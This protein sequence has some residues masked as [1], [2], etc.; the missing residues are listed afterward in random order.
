MKSRSYTL[1]DVPDPR[2]IEAKFV[3]N[4][5]V[6]DERTNDSGDARIRNQTLLITGGALQ[7]TVPRYIEINFD[8]VNFDAANFKDQKNQQNIDEKTIEFADSEETITNVGF[9]AIGETDS[10]AITR[11][12]EK[13]SSLSKVQGIGFNDSDQSKKLAYLMGVSQDDVQSIISP[14]ND[15]AKLMVNSNVAAKPESVFQMAAE[16]K[17]QSQINKRLYGLAVKGADD[18]SSLSRI[19]AIEMADGISSTF[20]SEASKHGLLD[21]DKEPTIHPIEFPTNTDE[22]KK[23]LGA[24][25]LGYVVTRY[26]HHPDGS[27]SDPK[28]FVLAGQHNTNLLDGEILYGESYTYEVRSVIRVDAIIDAELPGSSS[29]KKNWRVA[30]MVISKPSPSANVVSTEFQ[31][32]NEPDGVFYNF[33]YEAFGGLMLRWQVPS[34][35]SRDTKYFQ[36]FRRKTIF[37]PFTCIAMLDFDDS[38]IRTILPEQVR[39]E[40]VFSFP[41]ATTFYEDKAFKRDDKYI[42]AVAAIDA[43]GFSSGYSAQ[44]EVSFDKIRNTLVLK[45]ISRGGAPKQYPNFYVD[46]KLDDNFSVDS[47]T[48]D[49]IFDSG[50]KKM[51]VYFTP[52]ARTMSTADGNQENTFYTDNHA[53]AYSIQFINLDQQKSD[54]ALLTISDLRKLA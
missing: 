5:F 21:T 10:T 51:T 23:I 22:P 47:F 49:A 18:V 50:H 13:L 3:Y 28:N 38:D 25:C 34:G 20:L 27:K 31:A 42:Y 29:K 4:F 30:M 14:L 54:T 35:K 39:P 44:T 24:A 12:N 8:E 2:R 7:A 19:T 37:D 48:Q 33:N 53:G 1:V 41:G 26:H 9:V 40:R 17:I 11:L 52:D 36:I 6:H 15:S 16:A 43:H 32:P 45:S 46:P